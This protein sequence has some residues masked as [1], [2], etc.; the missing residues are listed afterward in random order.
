M[1]LYPLHN[2][3]L[4]FASITSS[5]TPPVLFFTEEVPQE[6]VHLGHCVIYNRCHHNFNYCAIIKEEV[7]IVPSISIIVK[8]LRSS[9]IS[10]QLNNCNKNLILTSVP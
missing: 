9:W 1:V 2:G 5:I 4:Y 10:A 8:Y 6:D 7:K 3:M